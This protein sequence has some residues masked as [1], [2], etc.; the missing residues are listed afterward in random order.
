MINTAITL[1]IS[2]IFQLTFKMAVTDYI[3]PEVHCDFL[4]GFF[5]L[6]GPGY[7]NQ[8]SVIMAIISA[9]EWDKKEVAEL[10]TQD[11][12]TDLIRWLEQKGTYRLH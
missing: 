12:A 4:S 8:K 5:S 9:I 6:V 10:R 1:Q 11:S 3:K 2:L 7:H